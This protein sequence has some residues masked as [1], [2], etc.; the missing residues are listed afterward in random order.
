ME[1]WLKLHRA[2]IESAVFSDPEVLKVWI[3][4]L[5]R[6]AYESHDVLF[7]GKVI[8]L[9]AGQIATGR[10]KIAQAT[11]LS[12]SKVYRALNILKNLGNISIK[13]NNKYS[14]ITVLNWEKFQSNSAG[15]NSKTTAKQQRNDNKATT[16]QQQNNTTK[17]YKE[18]KES[19]EIKK[20]GFLPSG[21]APNGVPYVLVDGKMYDE[22]GSEIN[23]AGFKMIEFGLSKKSVDF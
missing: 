18:Y 2:L 5:C 3:W 12:E 1:G 4:L 14:V 21:V 16:K 6:V 20:R 13:A 9:Q 23:A 15:V 10:K 22:D 8:Q 17:E 11:D 19:K 7:M